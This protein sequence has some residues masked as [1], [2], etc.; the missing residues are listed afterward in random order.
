[1][2]LNSNNV[3]QNTIHFKE[4]I[5]VILFILFNNYA[6][7]DDVSE[8]K[9]CKK[10]ILNTKTTLAIN[11]CKP[12]AE[13]GLAEAQYL[14][15]ELYDSP[16]NGIKSAKDSFFWH[17]K[18][19]NQ[20]H[21]ASQ[22]NVGNSYRY[23]E[24]VKINLEKSFYWTQK[25]AQQNLVDAQFNLGSMYMQGLGTNTDLKKGILLISKA[26]QQKNMFAE[27]YLGQI[28]LGGIGTAIDD[29]KAVMWFTRSAKQGNVLA[30]VKIGMIYLSGIGVDK[31]IDTAIRWFTRAALKG[32]PVAYGYV[33]NLAKQNNLL[34]QSNM[35]LIFANGA[36]IHEYDKAFKWFSIAAENGSAEAQ[37]NLG[38]AY[39][40]GVG[41]KVDFE[42]AKYWYKKSASLGYETAKSKLN[43]L[44]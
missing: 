11:K 4:I 16:I 26:A 35:G 6:H 43:Q 1:M 2:R 3:K 30:Q 12:L 33:I 40:K 28:Y 20:G 9:N 7:A 23:A 25:S 42:K 10:L 5:C 32:S 17:L 21:P 39:E 34:A 38:I 19:A 8:L 41:T 44:K 22:N 27:A 29:K 15:G 24:G 31:D 13:K 37:Y 36:G 14:M 18:A